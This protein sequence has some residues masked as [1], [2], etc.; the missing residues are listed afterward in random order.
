MLPGGLTQAATFRGVPG[1]VYRLARWAYGDFGRVVLV[2]VAAVVG[3]VLV[4][5]LGWVFR[6]GVWVAAI[7][8]VL[9]DALLLVVI[10]RVATGL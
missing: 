4:G 3:S 6:F 9:L 1:L 8:V 5:R 10:L 2:I 7:G